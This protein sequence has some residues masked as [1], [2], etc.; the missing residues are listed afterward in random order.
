VESMADNSAVVLVTATT[1]VTNTA[2][3][4]QEPRSW[5]LRST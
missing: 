1:T 5:R 2:G 4:D 3:A